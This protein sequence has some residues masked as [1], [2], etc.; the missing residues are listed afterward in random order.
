MLQFFCFPA[1]VKLNMYMY[2]QKKKDKCVPVHF[3]SHLAD[4]R[5]MQRPAHRPLCPPTVHIHIEMIDKSFADRAGTLFY[6]QCACM[7]V[8]VSKSICFS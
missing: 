4:R 1:V 6:I 7:C 3:V 5:A 8:Q 2:V